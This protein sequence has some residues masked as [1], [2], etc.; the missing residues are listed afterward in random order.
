M[1]GHRVTVEAGDHVAK[2]EQREIV[3]RPEAIQIGDSGLLPCTVELSCFMGSY[4]NYHVRVGDTLVKISDNCPVN[5]KIYQVG[6][7]AWIAFDKECA[8]LL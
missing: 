1:N 4:Q 8:H 7:T 6:D 3:L 2:G 5:K